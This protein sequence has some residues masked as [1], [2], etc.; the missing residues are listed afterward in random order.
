[1]GEVIVLAN[2]TMRVEI[3]PDHG[4][5]VIYLGPPAGPTWLD[6]HAWNSPL[7]ATRSVSYGSPLLD[8]LSE[9]RGGWQEL[10]PNAGDD[11]AIAGVPLPYHGELS[12][13]RWEVADRD[14]RMVA[15]RCAS[16]LPL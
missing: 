7:R 15:L 11:C 2:A 4:A 10:F 6:Y 1:M 8:W 14:P 9:Y 13:A 5:E 12:V 16:R 3:S